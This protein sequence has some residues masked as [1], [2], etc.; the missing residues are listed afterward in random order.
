M[1]TELWW[2]AHPWLTEPEYYFISDLLNLG[3]KKWALSISLP[4]CNYNQELAAL[5]KLPVLC[6]YPLVPFPLNTL[7]P[8]VWPDSDTL[9]AMTYDL[10]HELSNAN[11]LTWFAM[12]L[13]PLISMYSL[14]GFSHSWDDIV[15]KSPLSLH[16][17][18]LGVWTTSDP[19]LWYSKLPPRTLCWAGATAYGLT[20]TEACLSRLYY[21]F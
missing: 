1:L 8:T 2:V 13:L 19:W 9:W 3:F 12:W 6:A 4:L 16:F 11:S 17:T 10:T 7:W 21:L 14:F 15:V 20:N 18:E 5:H